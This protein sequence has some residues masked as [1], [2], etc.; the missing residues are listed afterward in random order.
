MSQAIIT[1]RGGSGG[2]GKVYT[3][4]YT[5]TMNLVY[6]NAKQTGGYAEFTSSGTL[7]WLGDPPEEADLFC[8]GGGGA[9]D[10]DSY[11]S[12]GSAG[13]S[14][15]GGGG[16][17]Y[18]TT[19]LAAALPA[20]T[21][22]TIGSGGTRGRAGIN[23]SGA[24]NRRLA[25]DGGTTSIG[26][27]CT[28]AGGKAS[29]ASTKGAAGGSGGGGG[30]YQSI[31]GGVYGQ[32]IGGAGGSNGSNGRRGTVTRDPAGV[33]NGGAGQGTPTTDLIGRRHA[34]GGGGAGGGAAG[35]SDFTAGKGGGTYG[36]GGYGGGGMGVPST[37]NTAY[38][39]NGGQGFA[40][41]GWGSY[42]E[43]LGLT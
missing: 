13:S 36:G 32:F 41:I 28:A 21:Q 37:Y 20:E 34:G 9:S 1:R 2:A 19:V 33:G 8:V 30:G 3:P 16:G 17:G 15:T 26:E 5:G 23:S 14:H 40:M 18:T 27:L 25:T 6:T 11:R 42:K 12:G 38:G 35:T 43:D 7:T 31:S 39:N 4:Q 22:V 10:I 24:S 29:A